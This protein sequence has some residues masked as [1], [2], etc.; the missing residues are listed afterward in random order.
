MHDAA[1]S[2]NMEVGCGK[3][4]NYGETFGVPWDSGI[5]DKMYLFWS[6]LRISGTI[7]ALIDSDKID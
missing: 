1:N 6:W 7:D 5:T 4:R 3:P 2:G